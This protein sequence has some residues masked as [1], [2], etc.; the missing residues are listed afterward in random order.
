MTILLSID[1]G[2]RAANDRACYVAEFH[3]AELAALHT[4]NRAGVVKAMRAGLTCDTVAVER[5]CYD[6]RIS[7]GIP[8]GTVIDLAWNAA[9]VAFTLAAGAPVHA[10]T[11]T[12]WIGTVPKSV[13]HRR[14]WSALTGPERKFFH[15]ETAEWIEA[16]AEK[17][18]RTRKLTE[19]AA[20][21]TL[22]AAGVGLFELGRIGKGGV[23]R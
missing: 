6:G 14:I 1:G 8:P 4:L 19:H 10:H 3:K 23:K 9:A 16:A 5:P 15:C 7:R 21:N 13:L 22:D 20:Y 11:P 2:N 17:Y 12:E 18:A